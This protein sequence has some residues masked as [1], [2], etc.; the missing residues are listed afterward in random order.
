MKV[1]LKTQRLDVLIIFNL[2]M[3]RLMAQWVRSY[4]LLS[5]VVCLVLRERKTFQFLFVFE[6]ML[7]PKPLGGFDLSWSHVF[8]SGL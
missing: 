4:L 2:A 8:G 1:S 6:Y 5:V 3:Q 7:M